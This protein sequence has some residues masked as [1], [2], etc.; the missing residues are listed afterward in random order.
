MTTTWLALRV[1]GLSSTGFMSTCASTPAAAAWKTWARPIS[2]PA[3]VTAEFNAMFCA[4][5]GA[6]DK[7]R[8]A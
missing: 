3:A 1:E 8:R 4:L 6:T 2:S 7:P 5:N